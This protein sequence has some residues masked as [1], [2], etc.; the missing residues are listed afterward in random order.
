MPI[1]AYPEEQVLRLLAPG[2]LL[3]SGQIARQ[4]ELTGHAARKAISTLARRGWIASPKGEARW[5]ISTL[6]LKAVR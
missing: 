1:R 4:A 6:G 3:D 2:G 5:S